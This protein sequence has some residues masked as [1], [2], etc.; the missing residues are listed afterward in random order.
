MIFPALDEFAISPAG[1]GVGNQA[2]IV[3]P[4]Q[5]ASRFLVTSTFVSLALLRLWR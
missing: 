1:G 5:P 2:S 4:V 3:D